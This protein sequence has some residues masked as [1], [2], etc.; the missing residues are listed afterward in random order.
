MRV[1][2]GRMSTLGVSLSR[3]VM[4][5]LARPWLDD[6]LAEIRV[7]VYQEM[8]VDLVLCSGLYGYNEQ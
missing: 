8:V 2:P 4:E 6:L 1:N 3:S 7:K 5:T